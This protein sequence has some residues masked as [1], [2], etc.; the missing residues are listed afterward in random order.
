[1]PWATTS[2]LEEYASPSDLAA[3][4]ALISGSAAWVS[5]MLAEAQ[6]QIDP[7][8]YSPG[9]RQQQAHGLLT[10]HLIASAG[11]LP[12]GG[13][14]G[15]I[16]SEANGPASRSFAVTAPS[17]TPDEALYAS[18]PYGRRFLAMR[19]YAGALSGVTSNGCT[20]GYCG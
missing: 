1:M 5:A 12:S 6:Q 4:Q 16:A 11:E 17:G 10:L 20:G 2:T 9:T 3:L 15:P 13:L 7:C 18:T 19:R 14:S 8:R